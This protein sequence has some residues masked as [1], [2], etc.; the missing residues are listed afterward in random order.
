MNSLSARVLRPLIPAASEVSRYLERVDSNRWYTNRGSLVQEL[1]QRLSEKTGAS[2]HVAILCTS[3]T[4]AIEAAVLATAGPAT[5]EKP[6]ALV[7]SYTFA[8]TALAVQRC[9]YQPWFVD[10]DPVT[11]ALNPTLLQD[12]HALSQTELS[13]PLRPTDPPPT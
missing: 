4:A 2:K 5:P 13:S 12:H 10:V 6:F 3:G 9:G 1:E 7:P 8:A 11:M